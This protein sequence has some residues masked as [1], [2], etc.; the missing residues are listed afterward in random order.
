MLSPSVV[1]LTLEVQHEDGEELGAAEAAGR[2]FR[3]RCGQWV[4]F[5]VP[6]MDDVGGFSLCSTPAQLP[7]LQ[8]AVRR[9]RRE[10]AAWV[11][12]SAKVGDTVGVR[13]GGSFWRSTAADPHA[14][15]RGVVLVGGGIGVSPLL[16]MMREWVAWRCGPGGRDASSVL[17]LVH[18]AAAA[19]DLVWRDEVAAMQRGAP[20][21]S[22]GVFYAATAGADRDEGA[23]RRADEAVAAARGVER[24]AWTLEGGPLHAGTLHA[25]RPGRAVMELARDFVE[26]PGSGGGEGSLPQDEAELYGATADP[27]WYLCGPPALL[28][29][30]SAT[31]GGHVGVHPGRVR[32]ERW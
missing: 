13:V 27:L 24:G 31:L 18:T 9:S 3:F 16:G 25:A 5:Y 28:D 17:A 32:F 23:A 1:Q 10:P 21:G 8:L 19:E 30:T 11:H 26:D 22:V 14:A 7:R 6:G 2:P 20:P 15:T 29:D 12:G 4:D